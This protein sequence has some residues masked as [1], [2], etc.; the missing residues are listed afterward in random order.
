[1]QLA[2]DLT[3]R[4]FSFT[5]HHMV[6]LVVALKLLNIFMIWAIFVT[7]CALILSGGDL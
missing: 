3:A 6:R 2:L 7:G 5:V 1:M 4:S